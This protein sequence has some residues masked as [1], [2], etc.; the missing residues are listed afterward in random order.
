M[1]ELIFSQQHVGL[2]VIASFISWYQVTG[3]QPAAR[4]SSAARI[5]NYFE[6]RL[7]FQHAIC[8]SVV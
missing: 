4:L 6:W 7:F 2:Y 1:E 8:I 3:R 5:S